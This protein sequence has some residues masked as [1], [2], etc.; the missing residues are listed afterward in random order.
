[1]KSMVAISHDFLK[2]ALHKQAR[3]IDATLGQGQ[4]TL[5]FLKARAAR[6][7]AF[8]VQADVAARTMERIGS[9]KVQVYLTGHEHMQE[10]LPSDWVENTDAILFNFGYCP[11]E[12]PQIQT[13]PK[14]SLEAVQQALTMLKV[15]GR[16][17][18]VFYPHEDW[19]EE[20][21]LIEDFL[22]TLD[23]HVFAIQKV[24]QLNAKKAPFVVCLEKKKSILG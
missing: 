14:T 19:E 6:I 21:A 10:S 24:I 23:P 7:A 5:F 17:A 15:K 20:S 8:E 3:A 13:R 9:S 1:M 12:N 22:M 4:D 2:P 16:M 11:H 18:L